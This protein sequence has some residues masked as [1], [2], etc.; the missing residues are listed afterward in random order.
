MPTY[1]FIPLSDE[2]LFDHPEKIRGP[3]IPYSAASV[4]SRLQRGGPDAR[5]QEPGPVADV[6]GSAGDGLENGPPA[7]SRRATW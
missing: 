7:L 6:R 5:P 4:V 1:V 2:L 3:L